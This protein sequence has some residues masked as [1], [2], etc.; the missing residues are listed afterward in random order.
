M[1]VGPHADPSFGAGSLNL[2]KEFER[3]PFVGDH[4][5]LCLG[6]GPAGSAEGGRGGA[7]AS[8]PSSLWEGPLEGERP[9]PLD[10]ED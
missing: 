10:G 2:F 6:A 8:S 1:L 7:G 3:P 5:E 4:A 9:P